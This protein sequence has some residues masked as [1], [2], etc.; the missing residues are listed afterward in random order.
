[1]K[2]DLHIS[3]SYNCALYLVIYFRASEVQIA[4]KCGSLT[5]G[6]IRPS[7]FFYDSE[8]PVYSHQ[9][10]PGFIKRVDSHIVG[11]A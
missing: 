2:L 1:M 8:R 11:L 4:W 5:S 10:V 3:G 7:F 6:E 9:H